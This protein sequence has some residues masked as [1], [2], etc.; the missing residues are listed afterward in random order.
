[1]R[2]LVIEDEKKIA[3]FVEEV[4][5]KD[6]HKVTQCDSVEAALKHHLPDY[7]DLI[8]LDLMLPG[9][10]GEDLV[11]E[12]R[13][14]KYTLP[15]LILSALGQISSKVELINMGADDYMTKPFDVQEFLARVHGLYRRHLEQ[16]P[17]DDTI[18]AGIEFHWK[19]GRVVRE[20]KEIKLTKKE[21]ELLQMLL[22]RK[23]Q[24]VTFEEILMRVWQSKLGYHSNVVQST[25]RRLRNKL[26]EGFDHSLIQNAH[27]VGYVLELK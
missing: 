10:R 18:H 22:E 19:Q 1:M 8:V 21:A 3:D 27:G 7:Q 12:L 20:G 15:I 4:L 6:G 2:I 13:K 14:K 17:M 5:T 25:V 9:K 24:I 26:D 11:R 23:G 16:H